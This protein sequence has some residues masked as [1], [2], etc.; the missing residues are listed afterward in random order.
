VAGYCQHE[1]A[2]PEARHVGNH[3]HEHPPEKLAKP[4][5]GKADADH[6]DC[7]ATS[8][9]GPPTPASPTL[10]WAAREAPPAARPHR[11]PGAPLT[12]RSGCVSSDRRD[13]RHLFPCRLAESHGNLSQ[14]IR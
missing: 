14:E 3:A 6:G 13:G 12:A 4:S 1:T 10:A 5:A 9:T 2:P 11:Y 8:L 7:H